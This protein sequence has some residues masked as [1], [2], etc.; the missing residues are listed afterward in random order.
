MRFLSD[1]PSIPDELLTARDEGRVVFFCGAGVSMARA[2]LKDFGGLTKQVLDSLGAAEDSEAR[3][4]FAMARPGTPIS[5]DRVFG[6]LE[7]E[8]SVEEVRVKVAEA[9]RPAR[10]ADLSAHR[11]LLDL[12]RG[13]D[14]AV[15]L[16]TTNFDRLFLQAAR[17]KVTCWTPP[18]LPDLRRR[19]AF[20]GIVHLHGITNRD[21]NG[22]EGE[23]F[24]V[25]S[26][27]F[28][29]A[30]L[31]DGWAANFMR[32]LLQRFQIVFVGYRADDPPVQY[33]LEA[34]GRT[35]TNTAGLY[36]FQDGPPDKAQAR[37]KSKGVTAIA[38]AANDYAALWS[39]LDAWATRARDP[40]AWTESVIGKARR[41]PAELTPHERGQVAH[42]VSTVPGAK[43]LAQ[44][45]PPVPAEWLCVF[46]RAIRFGMPGRLGRAFEAGEYIDPFDRYGLD[47]DEAPAPIAPNDH[48]AKRED[49]DTAWSALARQI[50]DSPA[51]RLAMLAGPGASAPAALSPR[52]HSLGWWLSKVCHQPAAVW[53]A[54]KQGSLHPYVRDRIQWAVDRGTDRFHSVVKQAWRHL[55]AFWEENE[56][57]RWRDWNDQKEE[58]AA[59]GWTVSTTERIATIL[60]PRLSVAA[61]GGGPLPPQDQPDIR[62][63]QLLNLDVE[64][65]DWDPDFAVPETHLVSFIR[66]VGRML[67]RATVLEA[68]A[69]KYR[70]RLRLQNPLTSDPDVRSD[71]MSF[72]DGLDGLLAKYVKIYQR[73]VDHSPPVARRERT[74]WPVD[75]HVFARLRIW[76]AGRKD[77]TTPAEAG[78][79]LTGLSSR[80]FWDGHHQRDLLVAIEARWAD[81]PARTQ[82][83]LAGRLMKGPPREPRESRTDFPIRRAVYSLDRI[84]WLKGKRIEFPVPRDAIEEL[85][86]AAPDWQEASAIFA[87]ESMEMRGGFV[88]TDPTPTPLLNEPLASLID[89]AERLRGHHSRDALLERD[90]FKGFVERKPVRALAALVMRTKMGEFPTNSWRTFLESEARKNDRPRLMA[91]IARRLAALPPSYL[92][93]IAHS[94]TSRMRNNAGTLLRGH[95]DAFKALWNAVLHLLRAKPDAGGSAII[96]SNRRQDWLTEAINAPPGHLVEASFDH[97]AMTTLQ[98]G[99]GLPGEWRAMAD[100]LLDLP[101]SQK[102][103]VAAALCAKL[104]RLYAVDPG[105]AERRLILLT[106]SGSPDAIAAFWD[107][108]LRSG[109]TSL[110]LFLRLKPQILARAH[111]ADEGEAPTLAAKILFRWITR[112]DPGKSRIVGDDELRDCLLRG[113]AEFRSHCLRLLAKW[114]KEDRAS[115][116]CDVMV[117]LGTV[118]PRQRTANG[119]RETSGLLQVLFT[120]DDDFPEGLKAVI[121]RLT[122]LVRDATMIMYGLDRPDTSKGTLPRRF[123]D[124]VLEVLHRVLP[125]DTSLWPY[126]CRSVLDIIAEETPALAT[127]SRLLELRRKLERDR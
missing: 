48:Y 4:L 75:D 123:P 98:S 43:A 60:Q 108:F 41:G 50:G 11:T 124:A 25:S 88:V 83:A 69:G 27:D 125:V 53:W 54:A 22:I 35:A 81:F 121:H 101:G 66:A 19:T 73:L 14:G 76:A 95:P 58:L 33:L 80:A 3:R 8:F 2:G 68:E 15:R 110:P 64:Y 86:R 74:L 85:R 127:D 72:I 77:L 63:D 118:W 7:R 94:V 56:P 24:V 92:A 93:P 122:P 115:R 21:Y 107:G 30:Y 9:L 13:P 99:N 10:R 91:L 126:N 52:L 40:Q 113:G 47:D 114:S 26:A 57:H 84:Y 49:P 45:D 79:L 44:A 105:W 34:L 71:G 87:A 103:H 82:T 65:P 46:D 100:D 120:L 104:D 18:L 106:Q 102:F 116:R 89:A 29:L 55:L 96:H 90:P 5:F 37:W 36:A 109:R 78:R 111:E 51:D 67:E 42:L 16:V 12:A 119:P 31:V 38:Y 112:M 32:Q 61:P 6:L 28:G 97:P 62:M 70:L 117:F 1:G 59:D 20:D 17:G 23:E 39:T